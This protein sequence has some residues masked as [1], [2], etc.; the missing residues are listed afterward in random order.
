MRTLTTWLLKCCDIW[1]YG[2]IPLSRARGELVPY[3]LLAC[4]LKKYVVTTIDM[5]RRTLV[6]LGYNRQD[7]SRSTENRESI[8]QEG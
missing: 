2:A 6:I 4:A 7:F 5:A 8:Q 3:A 1:T